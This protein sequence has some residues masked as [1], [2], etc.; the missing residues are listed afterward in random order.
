MT[1]LVFRSQKALLEL[2]FNNSI[3]GPPSILYFYYVY[4]DFYLSLD[5]YP[6][7]TKLVLYYFLYCQP[8]YNSCMSLACT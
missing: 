5:F 8:N 3:E 1:R 6:N 2:F 4:Y 7:L